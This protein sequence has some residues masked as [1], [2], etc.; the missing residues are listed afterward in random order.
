MNTTTLSGAAGR[1]AGTVA[2][3]LIHEIDWQEVAAL[4]LDCLTALAI[5]SLLAGRA[6]RR[7]WDALP[8][9]SEAL[10]RWYARL[11]VAAAPVAPPAVHPLVTLA[12]ELEQLTC[13]ELRGLV[14]TRRRMAKRELIEL[15][16][17]V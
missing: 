4:V 17:A 14:S 10:G 6:C 8:G 1:A 5:L 16:M 2:R 11:L 3:Y 12:D 9:L 15:V 7:A 13:R